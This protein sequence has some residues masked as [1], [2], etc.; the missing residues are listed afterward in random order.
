MEMTANGVLLG[1]AGALVLASSACAASWAGEADAAP[2]CFDAEVS[3]RLVQQ[4]PLPIPA[5]GDCIVFAWPWILDLDVEEIVRGSAP[6]GRLKVL[7]IQ[8]TYM[9][10]DQWLLRRNSQGGF[11]VLSRDGEVEPR[12]CGKGQP[13]AKPYIGADRKGLRDLE[14]AGRRAYGRGP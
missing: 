2:R 7:S 10:G 6:R 1:M 11:N 12:L 4:T 14:A 9:R 8:H 3:G 13:A 5:C